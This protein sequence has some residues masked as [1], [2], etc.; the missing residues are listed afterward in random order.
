M[1]NIYL[2]YLGNDLG[3]CGIQVG[4]VLGFTGEL[5]QRGILTR[6]DLDG[7]A[8]ELGDAKA[9]AA[10]A[11]KVARREDV[12]D[13]LAEGVYRTAMK[14]GELKGV[15]LSKYAV[16]EKEIAIGAHGVRSGKDFAYN[17]SYACSVQAGDHT[18]LA[19]VRDYGSGEAHSVLNDSMIACN[20]HLRLRG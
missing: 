11:E 5:Y 9:F 8:L 16:H 20:F 2:A 12:G 4:G 3:L 10:L 6:G 18:S 14:I 13:V 19:S 1:E 7:L 15:D 17:I